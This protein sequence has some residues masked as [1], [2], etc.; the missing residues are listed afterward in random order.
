[1]TTNS[2]ISVRRPSVLRTVLGSLLLAI[3]A[4]ASGAA[5]ADAD[6]V[7]CAQKQ[8][9]TLGF[10]AGLPDGIVGVKTFLAGEMYIRFMTANAEP[11]WKQPSLG[12]NTA[13]LWCERLAEANPAVAVYW[14]VYERQQVQEREQEQAAE[15]AADPQKIYEMAQAF[16]TGKGSI[17]RNEALAFKWYTRAAKLGHTLA[18]RNVA[19][20]Y[21]WGYGVPIDLALARHWFLIAAMQG[22]AE[23]QYMIGKYHS[24]SES[25]AIDW[26]WKAAQNGH[27]AA[28][29]ELE[30]RLDI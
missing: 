27:H 18:Q 3:V 10:Q 2:K 29:G 5:L 12:P 14:K 16:E 7:K 15:T 6:A 9:N 30:R 22:D 26:L 20:A 24:P 28:L 25:L 19:Q 1:M 21:H 13:S 8:L 23:S 4:G 17:R 11:G